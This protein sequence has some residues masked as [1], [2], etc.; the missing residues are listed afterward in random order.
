MKRKTLLGLALAGVAGGTAAG[1]TA[2]E[3]AIRRGR[4][5]P[6]PAAEDVLDEPVG[7]VHR[8]VPMSDG[9]EIHVIERGHGPT[10]VLLHGV[11]LSARAW[12]YQLIDLVAAGF[13]V[14]TLEHRGH[15]DSRAGSDGYTESR[16]AQDLYEVLLALRLADATLVGHSI[17]GM[18]ILQLMV[19]HPELAVDGTVSSIVLLSTSASPVLGNGVPVAAAGL[20]RLLTPVAGRGHIRATKGRAG[21]TR[22]P[23][24]LAALYCRLA[25][26]AAPSRMHVEWTRAMTSAISPEIVAALVHTLVGLD[27]REHLGAITAPTLVVVGSRDLLTPVWHSRYL[28]SH[29]RAAELHVLPGCGHMVMFERRDEFAQLLVDWAERVVPALSTT[30]QPSAR[31]SS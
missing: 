9:G 5:R 30:D 17:G 29:I 7:S 3:V 6:D 24:D 31:A 13:R 16:M 28:A 4:R 19:D 21:R 18:L 8:I 10:F 23:G 22:P 14:V 1:A 25:F 26:G 2:I 12:H 15:G 11:T 20:A 27:V